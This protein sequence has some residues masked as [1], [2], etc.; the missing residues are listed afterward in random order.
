MKRLKLS[1]PHP[2]LKEFMKYIFVMDTYVV[3]VNIGKD[4]GLIVPVP[5]ILFLK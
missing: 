5:I 3:L 2:D 1:I 4:M